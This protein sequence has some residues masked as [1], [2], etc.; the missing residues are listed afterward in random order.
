MPSPPRSE[1]ASLVAKLKSQG[2]TASTLGRENLQHRR[3]RTTIVNN[4]AGA[5]WALAALHT[6]A[7]LR[8]RKMLRHNRKVLAE[9]D[10]WWVTAQRSMVNAGREQSTQMVE[11]EYVKVMRSLLSISPPLG[12]PHMC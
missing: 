8:E 12:G 11:E 10:L 3:S 2:V 6:P 4:N 7:A 1:L 9:L 5:M